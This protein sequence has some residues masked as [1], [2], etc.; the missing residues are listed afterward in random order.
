MF[1]QKIPISF[2]QP[3]LRKSAETFVFIHTN[4]ESMTRIHEI[5]GAFF[6]EKDRRMPMFKKNEMAGIVDMALA[7][8]LCGD[9]ERLFFAYLGNASLGKPPSQNEK[10]K[11]NSHGEKDRDDRISRGD[12]D[13]NNL[14]DGRGSPGDAKRG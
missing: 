8:G 11:E 4:F 12:V 2:L 3:I 13:G 7:I 9:E 6:Y 5:R 14:C 10:R 1:H